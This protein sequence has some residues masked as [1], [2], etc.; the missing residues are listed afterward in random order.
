MP[1]QR[2]VRKIA[3]SLPETTED[4]DGFRFFVEGKQFAWAW[5]ER[6][7]PKKARVPNP[8]VIA[9]RVAD[10][11]DK[12]VLLASDP[13]VFFTEPHYDGY[14]A[15]LVRL[16]AIDRPRLVEVLTAAWR[17]RASKRLAPRDDVRVG[18]ASRSASSRSR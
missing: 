5:S 10:D 18:K 15:V 2:D 16:K 4:P 7:Q 12:R 14:P 11:L 17:C 9:V 1:T 6:V 3:L 13:E 8:D